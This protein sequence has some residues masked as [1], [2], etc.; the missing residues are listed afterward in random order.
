M[1]LVASPV[2]AALITFW[3]ASS[4]GAALIDVTGSG[5]LNGT[6]SSISGTFEFT[7]SVFV[8]YTV[9][10]TSSGSNISWNGAGSAEGSP[11]PGLSWFDQGEWTIELSLDIPA[12]L[13]WGQT[14][15][16]TDGANH[17]SSMWDL[18]MNS[19]VTPTI[20]DPDGQLDNQSTSAGFASF[21]IAGTSSDRVFNTDDTWRVSSGAAD[22]YTLRWYESPS[23]AVSRE[24]IGLVGASSVAVPEPGTFAAGA[25]FTG[26]AVGVVI[27]RRRKRKDSSPAQTN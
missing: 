15:V 16:I 6:G 21:G 13:V 2:L 7:G 19:A 26:S 27:C 20:S 18:T 9:E 8:D 5:T 10:L 4:A 23:G 17:P 12:A 11:N 14:P 3:A 24:W 1:R 22:L 25:L